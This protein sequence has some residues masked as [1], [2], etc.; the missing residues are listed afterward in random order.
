[1]VRACEVDSRRSRCGQCTSH[2]QIGPIGFRTGDRAPILPGMSLPLL[3]CAVLATVSS[4]GA[5]PAQGGG[6]VWG[7]PLP[8]PHAVIAGFAPPAHDWLA[9]HRGVDLAAAQGE[10]V[11]AAG[12][13]RVSFAGAVGGIDVVA[14]RHAGG[15]ETTYEPVRPS[16]HAGAVVREGQR[17][18]VI[19]G[20]LAHCARTCLHW[21]LRRA[22]AYLDPLALVGAE[23]VRLLP[24]PSASPPTN[25]AYGAGAALL[26]AT[27]CTVW[28]SRRR[29][30]RRTRR[31]W[32][33]GISRARR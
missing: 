6:P 21:G 19:N 22:G 23:Q 5:G 11:L 30:E 20:R 29:A 28:C 26:S 33:R 32:R 8:P 10:A 31:R 13:G 3:V 2:P 7:W 14:V 24:S 4:Q 16:V 18:G 1:M 9:G 27:F 25:G 15:L 17:L 12:D